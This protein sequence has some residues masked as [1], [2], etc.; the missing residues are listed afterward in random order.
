MEFK[1][2]SWVTKETIKN[3]VPVLAQTCQGNR[4]AKPT[5]WELESQMYLGWIPATQFSS[6]VYRMV[7]LQCLR[8]MTNQKLPYYQSWFHYQ[9]AH[10]KTVHVVEEVTTSGIGKKWHHQYNEYLAK[11]RADIGKYSVEVLLLPCSLCYL[12]NTRTLELTPSCQFEHA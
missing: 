4:S 5:P 2:K 12:C 6:W 10:W 11:E 1:T 8:E 9:S 7:L 3:H